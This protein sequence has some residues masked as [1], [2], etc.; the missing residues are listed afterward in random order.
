MSVIAT[1]TINNDEEMTLDKKTW[2][3]LKQV[4]AEDL[5]QYIEDSSDS[6]SDE[7]NYDPSLPSMNKSLKQL[8]AM[9]DAEQRKLKGLPEQDEDSDGS[10][11]SVQRVNRMEDEINTGLDQQ[12]EYQMLKSKKMAKK[13]LKNKAIV[14]LQRQKR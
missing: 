14:D 3:K 13:D 1:A 6:D 9:D 5:D 4:E 12:K 8:K 11:D 10:E 7:R 2:D